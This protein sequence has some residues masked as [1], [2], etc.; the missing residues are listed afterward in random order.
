MNVQQAQ[1]TIADYCKEMKRGEISV[2]RDYQRTDKVW[3]AGARSF[4]IETII[5]GYP[6][7]KLSLRQVTDVKSRS[8]RKEIVD[9][10]QRSRAIADYLEDA[11]PIKRKG[12]PANLD[13][14][15]YSELDEDDQHK[16]LDYGLA[17]DLFVGAS[18]EEIREV[19]RRINSYTVPLNAEEKRHSSFQGDFK[20]FIHRLTRSYAD[21]LV[22]LGVFK[23]RQLSR[24][25]DAKLFTEITHALINGIQT[26]KERE[27]TALYE[28][29]DAA[30]PD[31][32]AIEQR[33]GDAFDLL[34]AIPSLQNSELV[35]PHQFYSLFLAA[36]HALAPVASL[37][38]AFPRTATPSID[39]AVAEANLGLLDDALENATPQFRE[40]V[41]AGAERTNVA[42]QR[43][44]RMRWYSRALEPVML[45]AAGA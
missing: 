14:R 29:F 12:A 7:P 23:E 9:G 8:T 19:F 40:F 34:L 24:L 21:T 4:L 20:W 45:D 6:V 39:M 38:G 2:N 31:E 22:G 13:G 41:A 33:F 26:T 3:P 15:R 35:K 17:V 37:Q 27:L 5:L 1:Y 30:F 43:A 16:F 11:F 25:A 18:N 32:L 10:Q 36:T 44:A 28:Q 42:S